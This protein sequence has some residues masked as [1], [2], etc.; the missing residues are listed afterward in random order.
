MLTTTVTNLVKAMLPEPVLQLVRRL[1][2]VRRQRIQRGMSNEQI[3]SE[4]YAKN[5]WGGAKGEFYSGS[6]S[7]DEAIVTPYVDAVQRLAE[8]RGFL[9]LR[10]VDLGCG[11]FRVG[12]RLLPLCSSYVGVDVVPA[13][14]DQNNRVSGNQTTRFL[15]ADVTRDTIPEGDVCFVRQIL[16][17]LSNAEIA[18][19]LSK[20]RG[21]RWVFITE[22]LPGPHAAVAPNIDKVHGEDIRVECGS[23]VYLD[24]P[25]FDLPVESLEVI[26]DVPGEGFGRG[27]DPGVIRTVLYTPQRDG[28]SRHPVGSR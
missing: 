4:I 2:R 12:Q 17:H 24:Q 28:S 1:R 18:L 6:G 26:L 21:F 19:I 8:E 22:H 11:D 23:G 16:Q 25:P 9:G 14:V 27:V 13:L 5:I 20:L 15:A 10:F 7:T 3:F